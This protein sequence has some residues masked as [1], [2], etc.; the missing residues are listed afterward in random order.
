MTATFVRSDSMM[1][2]VERRRELGAIA[3]VKVT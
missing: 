3:G 2:I 1:H